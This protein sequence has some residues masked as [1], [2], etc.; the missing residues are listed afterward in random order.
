MK[1]FTRQKSMFLQRE[2]QIMKKNIQIAQ[3]INVNQ[4]EQKELHVKLDGYVIFKVQMEILNIHVYIHEF[5][6]LETYD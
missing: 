3:I 5:N 2:K 1:I 6:Y 4:I